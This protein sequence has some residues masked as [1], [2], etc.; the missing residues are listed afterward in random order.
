M[1]NVYVVPFWPMKIYWFLRNEKTNSSDSDEKVV[2]KPL[3]E[4]NSVCV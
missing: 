4:A 2:A 1:Y 3:K